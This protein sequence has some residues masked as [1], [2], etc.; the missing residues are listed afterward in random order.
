MAVV[1]DS[2]TSG[3]NLSN[4]R[5]KFPWSSSGDRF[6]AE[7]REDKRH[8]SSRDAAWRHGFHAEGREDKRPPHVA[9]RG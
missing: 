8:R 9:L 6:H 2:L 4:Q 7:G 5:E 1:S 3:K